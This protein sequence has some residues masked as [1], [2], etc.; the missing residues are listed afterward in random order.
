[1]ARVRIREAFDLPGRGTVLLVDV[2]EGRVAAGDIV[3]APVGDGGIQP[4]SVV[5]VEFVDRRLSSDDPESSL[6][7]VV[8]GFPAAALSTPVE[9][10]VRDA[11]TVPTSFGF[12][13]INRSC[14]GGGQDR[15][16]A[17]RRGGGL[18]VALADGA[19]GVGGG[20]AAAQ[21]LVDEANAWTVHGSA[22]PGVIADLDRRLASTTG[23]EST[24]VIL[25]LSATGVVGASVGDSEA[26]IVRADSVEDLTAA[27][28]R[29]PL[30]GSGACVPVAFAV[31]ALQG[32]T[33]LVAS[34][35]LFK[36][37]KRSDIARVA[38]LP[39]LGSAVA[40][41]VDLVT[42]RSGAVSDD[43]SVILCR[44]AE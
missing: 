15:V 3:D 4:A 10:H 25:S 43:V 23:G 14:R 17:F 5:G 11:S 6:A 9:A 34:D 37:A 7:L 1:M 8:E 22:A 33:L 26:W 41:L 28:N 24:A 35:G 2:V 31:G 29:K 30:V 20:A 21:F 38:M 13:T 42:L 40:G 32:G 39:E 19:G 44:E 36:Y 16:A 12:A 27:Q 18:V